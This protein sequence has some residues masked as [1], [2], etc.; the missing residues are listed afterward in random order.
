MGSNP[1]PRFLVQLYDSA[2]MVK[3]K[4]FMCGSENTI[5]KKADC[6]F[7]YQCKL[8]GDKWGKQDIRRIVRNYKNL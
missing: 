5:E 8:C 6:F 1:I 4:Y 7:I 2:M 3:E